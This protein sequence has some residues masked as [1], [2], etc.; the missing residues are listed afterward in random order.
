M[1]FTRQWVLKCHH[2]WSCGCNMCTST[3]RCCVCVKKR[4]WEVLLQLLLLHIRCLSDTMQHPCTVWRRLSDILGVYKHRPENYVVNSSSYVALAKTSS[5]RIHATVCK[6][7][8]TVTT[9]RPKKPPSCGSVR[10]VRTSPARQSASKANMS[11]TAAMVWF[12]SLLPACHAVTVDNSA[13]NYHAGFLVQRD[14]S[15]QTGSASNK[16]W[17]T[18]TK[19]NIAQFTSE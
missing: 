8:H 7:Q 19:V 3:T 15:R 13:P 5:A 2:Q 1:T 18:T 10:S 11:S 14:H 4:R 16:E 17:L 9:R 12:T 6:L